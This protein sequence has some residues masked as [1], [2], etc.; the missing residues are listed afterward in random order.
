MLPH[1]TPER[2][3]N[4]RNQ[5]QNQHDPGGF[6]HQENSGNAKDN[7]K[8]G[9]QTKPVTVTDNRPVQVCLDSMD[10]RIDTSRRD[11][12]RLV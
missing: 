3:G 7:E 9:E 1:R 10:R 2:E 4:Q 12:N 6:G 5:H 8:N 11:R